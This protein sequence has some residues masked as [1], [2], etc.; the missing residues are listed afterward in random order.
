MCPSGHP[1]HIHRVCSTWG[2]FHFKTFDGDVFQ[3]P[4]SCAYILTSHCKADYESFNIQLQRQQSGD[5][6]HIERVSM[7]LDGTVVELT[8]TS[9]LINSNE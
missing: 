7:K 2:N 3:L 1:V 8:K 5:D 4:S 9:V 6:V